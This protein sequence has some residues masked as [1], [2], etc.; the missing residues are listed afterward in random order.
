MDKE[1]K[2]KI[3]ASIGGHFLVDLYSPL[4]PIILPA[5]ILNM[6]LSFFLAG[7]IVTA[8]NVTSS[9]VQPFAGLYSDRTGKKARI[10]ICVLFS[11]VGISLAVLT[12]NYLLMLVLVS[13]AALGSALFHPA[14]M[15][16]VFRLSPPEKRGV[17]NSIFTTSGSVSY[18]IGPLIA[19]IMI[20]FYGLSSIAWLVIPGILGAIWIYSV[21]KKFQTSHVAFYE[22]KRPVRK[23]DREKYWWVPAG[24]V[25]TLCSLRAWTYVGII[26]YL[27]ALLIL[28]QQGMDTITTSLIVTIMLF[29]GVSGQIT[30]GYLSDRFGRKNMLVFGFASAVPFFCLIFLTQ[31]WLMYV[32]IFMYSFFACFCYVTSVTMM[33]ELLPGS[34]GF[35]S[36]LTLG[37]CVG[38]GGIGAAIIGWA[39]D[40][41]GSLPDAMFL[42]V[43]PTIICPILAVFIK[44]PGNE[45]IRKNES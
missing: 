42:M 8:F 40:G 2:D 7:L 21:D 27:P 41:M 15:E 44:Y 24:L 29:I 16:T 19:G 45:R 1:I 25:V 26:T 23:K 17:F 20:T 9:V 5:L 10:W 28:G 3:F 39:A 34:V 37:L 35:A 31:G 6:N 12:N 38:V 43:I 33:Q 36:G 30:G 4:L 14:A 13:C 32:G 11:S 18:S 22:R